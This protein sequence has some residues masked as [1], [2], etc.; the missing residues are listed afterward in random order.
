M[1]PLMSA[2]ALTIVLSC[3]GIAAAQSVG[4]A[5]NGP[6]GAVP[7][8]TPERAQ[9]FIDRPAGLVEQ[10]HDMPG[11]LAMAVRDLAM[12]QPQSISAMVA[13]SNSAAPDQL[14]AIGAG[15]G[16][17]AAICVLSQ[18]GTAQRIQEAVLATNKP[19]IVLAFTSVVGEVA[20][21]AVPD[22]PAT[23]EATAGGNRSA[24]VG[25][26]Q[27][28]GALSSPDT[29]SLFSV[30]GAASRQSGSVILSVSPSN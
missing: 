30:V 20:T 21:E 22:L 15:L 23:G 3:P 10:N 6:C 4:G 11:S 27:A 9:E 12:G 14:R 29:R 26:Q 2:L 5:G 24:P 16:T 17:A 19:E 25:T 1:R 8:L 18:P 13:L 7:G 28:G